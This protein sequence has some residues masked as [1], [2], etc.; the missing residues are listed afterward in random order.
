MTNNPCSVYW[1]LILN[2]VINTNDIKYIQ[3]TIPYKDSSIHFIIRWIQ[4]HQVMQYTWSAPICSCLA[5]T[6]CWGPRW[7]PWVQEKNEYKGI[8]DKSWLN[9]V[10]WHMKTAIWTVHWQHYLSWYIGFGSVLST[11]S[12]TKF[13]T[14]LKIFS[15]SLSYIRKQKFQL[16]RTSMLY[17]EDVPLTVQV[18]GL[19]ISLTANMK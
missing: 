4:M 11:N 14:Q 15:H 3:S 5:W 7:S 6:T 19:H 13:Y 8:F 1:L 10:P 18:T 16:Q 17:D 9:I 2:H 12:S